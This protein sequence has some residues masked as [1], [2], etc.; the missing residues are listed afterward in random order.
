MHLSGVYVAGYFSQSS[1]PWHLH[2][3]SLVKDNVVRIA[4]LSVAIVVRDFLFRLNFF[5]GTV[6][7]DERA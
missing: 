6:S 5:S 4:R 3:V 2:L 1:L 7:L